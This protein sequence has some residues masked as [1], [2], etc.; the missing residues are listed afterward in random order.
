[1][2]TAAVGVHCQATFLL[3]NMG[4]LF[5]E[6]HGVSF[7]SGGL[8][9]VDCLLEVGLHQFGFAPALL[10]ILVAA[11]HSHLLGNLLVLQ[12]VAVHDVAL[13]L[14]LLLTPDG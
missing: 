12:L 14:G 4:E 13:L 8:V 6:G 11:L 3:K 7:V 9:G 5:I 10:L 1:M 2:P